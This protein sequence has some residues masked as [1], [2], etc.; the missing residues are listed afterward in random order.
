MIDPAQFENFRLVGG[1][2]IVRIELNAEPLTDAL[3]REALARTG[4]TGKRLEIT[5]QPGLSKRNSL[6][7]STTKSSRR[8]PSPPM[9]HPKAFSNSMR[10][11]LIP[12]L[13]PHTQPLG[14]QPRPA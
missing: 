6:S 8:P 4:I 14:L 13:T 9:I 10:A 3:G 2:I 5:I 7:R 1:F 11:I 12:P